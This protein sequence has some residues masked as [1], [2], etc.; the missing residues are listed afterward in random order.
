M[1]SYSDRAK[2]LKQRINPYSSNYGTLRNYCVKRTERC[3][4][5]MIHISSPL[6]LCYPWITNCA[7][8]VNTTWPGYLDDL[9]TTEYDHEWQ[10]TKMLRKWQLLKILTDAMNN[11]LKQ[12]L[13]A[14]TPTP[15]CRCTSYPRSFQCDTCIA[16]CMFSYCILCR[17]LWLTHV[18]S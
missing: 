5:Q 1:I 15:T 14:W 6:V 7:Y 10:L 4:C 3:I 16:K 13:Y 11:A 18:V 12:V 17:S 9:I 8:T 2:W